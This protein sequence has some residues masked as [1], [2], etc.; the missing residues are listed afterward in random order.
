MVFFFSIR[1][2][3]VITREAV[4]GLRMRASLMSLWTKSTIKLSSNHRAVRPSKGDRGE[5]SMLVLREEDL[6]WWKPVLIT[7]ACLFWK[8]AWALVHVLS[9]M[10]VNE[11]CSTLSKFSKSQRLLQRIFLFDLFLLVPF[12]NPFPISLLIKTE[13][14]EHKLTFSW[15]LG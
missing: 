1:I 10:L 6:S 5:H 15:W 7:E 2:V 3:E 14:T 13:H 9:I 12:E 4:Y 8:E 11:V